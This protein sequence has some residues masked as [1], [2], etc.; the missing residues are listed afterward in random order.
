MGLKSF[1]LRL[2]QS[3]NPNT[4]ASL[5]DEKKKSTL[6]HF[7]TEFGILF[8]LMAVLFVPAFYLHADDLATRLSAFTSADLD[9]NF[10]SEAPVTLIERPRITFDSNA[11]SARGSWVVF[12]NEALFYKQYF[13]FGDTAI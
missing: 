2:L 10:S 4:Y 7:F 12:G 6:K 3:C 8:L 1:A 13:W 11:A 5:T 9:G